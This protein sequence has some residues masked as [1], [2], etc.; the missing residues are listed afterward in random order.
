MRHARF[1]AFFPAVFILLSLVS[2]DLMGSYYVSGTESE[3][4]DLRQ[5]AKLLEDDRTSG[6]DR[7][8]VVQEIGQ[9]YLRR[10]AYAKLVNFL[11]EYV[12]ANPKDPYNAY[13]LF[14]IAH[15]YAAMDAAPIAAIYYDRIVKNYPDLMVKGESIHRT[16][17]F[18][19]IDTSADAGRR[20]DY[21]RELITRFPDRVDLGRE[22]FLLGKD[23]EAIGEWDHAIEAYRKYLP[24]F[25][26][27]I[28]GYPDAF[29]YAR[30]MVDFANSPKDW[31]FENL[32][33]LVVAVKEA[34]ASASPS[35]LS[36]LRSKV[37]FFAMSWH[38]DLNDGSSRVVF[39]FS[40]FMGGQPIAFSPNLESNSNSTEGYLRTWGW[41]DR[42]MGW[43]FYFR[44]INFPVDP[45][46]HG[47]WEWA[48]IYYGERLE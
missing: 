45:E 40:P 16:C 28:P 42:S 8:A 7:F 18:E 24:W 20:I 15:A 31:T 48:G 29:S 12:D 39:D 13:H 17:L 2:C 4:D 21:R 14:S 46:I 47:R 30:N 26:S 27:P 36:K 1:R 33:A 3:R 44:K 10:K 11:G 23:F 38:Q 9:N 34:L 25:G 19:L 35:R 43:T 5:L 41:T 37:S 32:P 6:P 22:L